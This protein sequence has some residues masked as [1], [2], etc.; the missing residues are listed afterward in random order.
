MLRYREETR[1]RLE[2]TV[3]TSEESVSAETFK[4]SKARYWRDLVMTI[5]SHGG[6]H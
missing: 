1:A 2:E 5:Q 3:G 6:V 4:K